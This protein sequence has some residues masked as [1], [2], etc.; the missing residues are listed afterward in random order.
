MAGQHF[1]KERHAPLLKSFGKKCVIRVVTD[2]ACD[3]PSSIP[4][5]A[6]IVNQQPH[7][8]RYGDRRVRI[9]ELQ[10]IVIG[11]L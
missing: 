11:K 1:F 3:R 7:E 8:F 2:A 6:I 9:I 10:S 4:F 5:V